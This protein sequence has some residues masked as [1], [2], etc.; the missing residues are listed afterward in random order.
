M[1]SKHRCLTET[2]FVCLRNNG[3]LNGFPKEIALV[4]QHLRSLT[5]TLLECPKDFLLKVPMEV[6]TC[7]LPK[8]H[9]FTA[10]GI[11]NLGDHTLT[12]I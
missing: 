9:F 8:L 2:K 10:S 5:W 4:S 6:F 12:F 7:R 1:K 3:D 11:S